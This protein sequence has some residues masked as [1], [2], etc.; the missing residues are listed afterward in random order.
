MSDIQLGW[1]FR[2]VDG[3]GDSGFVI[4]LSS[5]L[6]FVGL[7]RLEG[8]EGGEVWPSSADVL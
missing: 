6:D 5:Q 4:A 1:L 2:A 3:L 7:H 8:L